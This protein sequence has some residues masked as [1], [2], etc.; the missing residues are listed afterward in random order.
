[1]TKQELLDYIKNDP[2]YLEA[3]AR[4]K[5]KLEEKEKKKF[6]TQDILNEYHYGETKR[7]L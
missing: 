4:R 5:K 6:I 2:K 1:M 7:I 3:E